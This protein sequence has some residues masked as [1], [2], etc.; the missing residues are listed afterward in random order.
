MARQRTLDFGGEGLAA[1]WKRLPERCRQNAV[2]QWARLIAAAAQRRPNQ[3]EQGHE[4]TD[5]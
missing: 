4:R 1:I 2:A 3:K 5:R